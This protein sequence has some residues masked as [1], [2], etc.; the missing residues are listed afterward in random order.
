MAFIV[1]FILGVIRVNNYLASKVSGNYNTELH[2]QMDND[3]FALSF[4]K[5]FYSESYLLKHIIISNV[6]PSILWSVIFVGM[7]KSP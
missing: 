7:M 4:S 5:W 6:G 1:Q 2:A 3:D